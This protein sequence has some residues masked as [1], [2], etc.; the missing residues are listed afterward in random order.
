LGFVALVLAVLSAHGAIEVAAF[1]S[2]SMVLQRDLRVPVWG[3][4]GVGEQVTVAFNGQTVQATAH[5][6]SVAAYKGY[7][8]VWLQPMSAGG[9]FDMVVSGSQS[10][11]GITIKSVLV[12]DVWVCSGQSNMDYSITGSYHDGAGSIEMQ[13]IPP[14]GQPI[15]QIRICKIAHNCA[16]NPVLDLHKTSQWSLPYGLE[17]NVTPWRSFSQETGKDMSETGALF[18]AILYKNH[19]VPLG[20]LA[21]PMGS[22]ALAAWIRPESAD[23]LWYHACGNNPSGVVQQR[24][25]VRFNPGQANQDQ[26]P[27]GCYSGMIH[28]IGGYGIKGVIWWQ[29]ENDAMSSNPDCY[30]AKGG[31]RTLIRDW[32]QLWGQGDF[33]FIYVQ[34]QA[35][36]IPQG[37]LIHDQQL[38]ALEEPNTGMAICFDSC[39][40]VHPSNRIIAANRLVQCALNLAYGQN[41]VPMGPIYKSMSI[42]SNKIR[43]QFA[44]AGNGLVKHDLPWFQGNNNLA[45]GTN[46]LSS[47]ADSNAPF[48]IAGT[49]N[50]FYKADAVIDNN[51]VLV[52][53]PSVTAPKNVHYGMEYPSATQSKTP[54]YN[55]AN[56]PASMFRTETWSGLGSGSTAA[57][58]AASRHVYITSNNRTA[59]IAIN[60]RLSLV[61][62]QDKMTKAVEYYTIKGCLVN[63]AVAG[64]GNAA[65]IRERN[66]RR[67]L[68]VVR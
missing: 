13:T 53:C 2:D 5:D 1:F 35:S 47:S 59:H 31:F 44:Y 14:A 24:A 66:D 57:N 6:S 40:G 55:N 27:G 3:W 46:V 37:N 42:E 64:S 51:T 12:G 18:I 8:K 52:S 68:T 58:R 63:R 25:P 50:V 21:A 54:L 16:V 39:G 49:D 32:R 20:L 43:I 61:T 48:E 11:A 10:A 65:D 19:P 7:W 38:Q 67:S 4:A 28:P 45:V 23:D 26:T 9:P 22:T 30:Y 29:G 60:G 56:L 34:L 15:T 62:S 36:V 41:V 33:P 17:G